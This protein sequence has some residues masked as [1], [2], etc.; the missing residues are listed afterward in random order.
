MDTYISLK[1]P[2]T[3]NRVIGMGG[4]LIVLVSGVTAALNAQPNEIQGTYYGHGDTM[5]I[6]D[7]FC[8]L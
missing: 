7:T 4:T 5:M 3:K 1:V 8:L 2:P 6:P